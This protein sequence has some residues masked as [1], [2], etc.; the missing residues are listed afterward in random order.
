MKKLLL[1]ALAL[2]SSVSLFAQSNDYGKFDFEIGFNIPVAASKVD[3]MTNAIIPFL[4]VEGR[5]QLEAH[6]VDVGFQIGISGI[7]RKYE[8]G[9]DR[10]N[11]STLMAISDW[12]FGRGKRINPYVGIGAG[13]SFNGEPRS[14]QGKSYTFA[15]APRV[16]VR[17]FKFAN[18]S[19]GYLFNQ[20]YYSRLYCNLGFY[21]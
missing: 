10:Y 6:P 16:G 8:G 21:F 1:V 15:V 13:V 11:S 5:W 20:K 7:K 4:Y 19:V 17:L 3:G 9:F 12:Q 2:C 14:M 18:L